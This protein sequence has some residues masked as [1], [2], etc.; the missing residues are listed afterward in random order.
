MNFRA[1]LTV[2][3]NISPRNHW[4]WAVIMQNGHIYKIKSFKSITKCLAS[5]ATFGVLY[6]C[7]ALKH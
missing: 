5:A 3:R 2:T 1:R 7:K 6:W 4:H